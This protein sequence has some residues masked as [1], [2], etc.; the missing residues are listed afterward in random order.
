M[1]DNKKKALLDKI[2]TGLADYFWHSYNSPD[3]NKRDLTLTDEEL[4]RRKFYPDVGP[5]K[6][7]EYTKRAPIKR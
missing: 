4:K 5:P 6:A 2:S 3:Q 1:A 7:P